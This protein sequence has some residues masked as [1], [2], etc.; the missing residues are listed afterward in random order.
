MFRISHLEDWIS[1]PSGSA[2][3]H[4]LLAPCSAQLDGI[5]DVGG[6]LVLD[7]ALF[8]DA[9]TLQDILKKQCAFWHYNDK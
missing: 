9:A 8:A 4:T 5:R 3:E 2:A 7:K 1:Q 6:V